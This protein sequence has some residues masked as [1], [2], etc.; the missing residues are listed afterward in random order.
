MDR[1]SDNFTFWNIQTTIKEAVKLKEEMKRTLHFENWS[2]HF[3]SKRINHQEYQVLVLK[4]EQREVKL[5]ALDLPDGKAG[6][7]VKG[8][9]AVLEE[10]NL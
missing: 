10:Y 7:V 6:T 5:K 4:N 8:I 1:R 9:T 2:L 3:D